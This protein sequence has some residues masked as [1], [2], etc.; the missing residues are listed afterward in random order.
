MIED[1]E[2]H[3]HVC[4]SKYHKVVTEMQSVFPFTL[5]RDRGKSYLAYNRTK[6]EEVT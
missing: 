3:K 2:S 5:E 4:T 6:A 1:V